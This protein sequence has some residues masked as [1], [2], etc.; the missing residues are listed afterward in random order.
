L[1][2]IDTTLGNYFRCP[3]NI[4]TQLTWEYFEVF[5]VFGR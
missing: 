3:K 1:T 4:F 5:D 2:T